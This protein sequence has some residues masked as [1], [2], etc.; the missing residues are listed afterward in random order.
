MPTAPKPAKPAAVANR[1]NWVPW[2]AGALALSAAVYM[3]RDRLTG[4]SVAPR[5]Q[6]SSAWPTI[7]GRALG[8]CL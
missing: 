6:E 4:L 3:L 1:P 7:R 2:V 5:S 8:S